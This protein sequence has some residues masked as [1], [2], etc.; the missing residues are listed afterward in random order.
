MAEADASESGEPTDGAKAPKAKR[1]RPQA[2]TT[3]AG[4]APK[5]E[6]ESQK[7]PP[8][9]PR[10]QRNFPA[11]SFEEAL[12]LA[13]SLLEFGAGQPVR[14][15]SLF[16]HLNKSPESG[17]SRQLITNGNKYGLIKGGY[18]AEHLELTPEGKKAAD[19]QIQ[20]RERA[21]ARAQLAILDVEPFAGLYEKFKGLRLPAKAALI[22]AV[23]EFGVDAES[24][25]EAVDTFIVNLRIGRCETHG[26]AS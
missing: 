18:Q 6:S 3:A 13:K 17:P 19:E 9:R 26:R 8:R 2:S 23:K 15:V 12:A 20:V 1:T 16:N 21:R 25:E 14:R 10:V 5:V 22:D 7:S 24:A 11:S 4:S